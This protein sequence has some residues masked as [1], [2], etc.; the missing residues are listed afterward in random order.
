MIL[1]PTFHIRDLLGGIGIEDQIAPILSCRGQFGGELAA[2][3]RG[4]FASEYN[5]IQPI[6]RN[7]QPP[8]HWRFAIPDFFQPKRLLLI[9]EMVRI[10][11]DLLQMGAR[12]TPRAAY[13]TV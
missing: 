9:E 6:L 3:P 13:A 2:K 11:W 1:H 7:D 8:A 5:S 12:S 4:C 10:E